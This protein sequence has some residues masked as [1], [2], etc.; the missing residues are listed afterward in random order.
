MLSKRSLFFR[1]F[2]CFVSGL[3][4]PVGGSLLKFADFPLV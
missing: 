2:V 1:Y 3:V 4:F